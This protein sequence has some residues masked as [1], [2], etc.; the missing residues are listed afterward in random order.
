MKRGRC[1]PALGGADNDVRATQGP[2]ARLPRTTG[3]VRSGSG[4][5]GLGGS[6]HAVVVD[7]LAH[8]HGAGN[9]GSVGS[10]TPRAGLNV[11]LSGNTQM[12]AES[13]SPIVTSCIPSAPTSIRCP[14]PPFSRQSQN[15]PACNGYASSPRRAIPLPLRTN[16]ASSRAEWKCSSV[17]CVSGIISSC[18]STSLSEPMWRASRVAYE[19]GSRRYCRAVSDDALI[20]EIGRRLAEATPAQSKIGIALAHNAIMA[21]HAKLAKSSH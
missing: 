7:P 20:D 8:R 4:P 15:D 12:S 3:I 1:A 14:T 21:N 11:R 18:A 13:R 9:G 16:H 2:V 19:G 5:R 17:V 6:R 10:S